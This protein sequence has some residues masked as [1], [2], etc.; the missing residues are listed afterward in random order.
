MA[1]AVESAQ[2]P[3]ARLDSTARG[4]NDVNSI[5]EF[6]RELVMIADR[7]LAQKFINDEAHRGLKE[8][9]EGGRLGKDDQATWKALTFQ[10]EDFKRAQGVVQEMQGVLKQAMREK[11]ASEADYEFLMGNLVLSGQINVTEKAVELARKMKEKVDHM[12]KDREGYDKIANH[13]LVRNTGFLKTGPN[14]KDKIDVP[15]EK[16]FLKMTVP[17]RRKLLEGVKKA[18]PKAEEYAKEAGKVESVEQTEAYDQLLHK[19]QFKDKIIGR[20]TAKK[21]KEGFKVIDH[22]EKERWIKTFE[23]EMERYQR[24]WSDIRST[25]EGSDLN[26]MEGERDTMGWSQLSAEFGKTM[27]RVY[28]GNLDDLH[29]KKVIS[30]HTKKAFSLDIAKRPLPEQQRYLKQL[31]SQMERYQSLRSNIDELKDK[32]AQSALNALYESE[33]CGYTE[34]HDLYLELTEKKTPEKK[35]DDKMASVLAN[36]RRERVQKGIKASEAGMESREQKEKMVAILDD[37]VRHQRRENYEATDYLGEVREE[38]AK[39][40]A[41]RQKK[42]KK[43]SVEPPSASAKVGDNFTFVDD[44]RRAR[45]YQNPDPSETGARDS[46][47]SASFKKQSLMGRMFSPLFGKKDQG[48]NREKKASSKTS[49][50]QTKSG[51]E[52][53]TAIRDLEQ[54]GD[55]NISTQSVADRTY[56]KTKIHGKQDV[57]VTQVRIERKDAMR[58]LLHEETQERRKIHFVTEDAGLDRLDFDDVRLYRDYL[59]ASLDR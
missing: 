10:R 54:E 8:V 6:R 7:A 1:S 5:H 4:V 2:A 22:T 29:T 40:E 33:T 20:E 36:V 44:I 15:D 48:A 3:E 53:E 55:E 25:L 34:I 14:E 35:G 23:G 50:G 47:S 59:K 38:R 58:Y 11:I 51:A 41:E 12:K 27:C 16:A 43:K 13:K 49:V 28:D 26:E 52:A 32:K 9:S 30:N 46:D 57:T 39:K 45:L 37:V 31:D 19:A 17:E 56:Q 42:S 18:L 24:L 21:F